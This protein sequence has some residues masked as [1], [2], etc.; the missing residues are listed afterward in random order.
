[1]IGWVGLSY[2][3]CDKHWHV[4]FGAGWLRT[5][6]PDDNLQHG[7]H[8]L[9]LSSTI[10]NL[11]G[12]WTLLDQEKEFNSHRLHS[13]EVTV[14]VQSPYLGTRFYKLEQQH[15]VVEADLDSVALQ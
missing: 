3:T 11:Q 7:E 10:I 8:N 1:M 5:E 4:H 9:P 15:V 14:I 12:F 2:P 13:P 6:F